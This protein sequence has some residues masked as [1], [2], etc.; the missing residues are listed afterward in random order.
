MHVDER[1]EESSEYY[2]M[3]LKT[4]KT[5]RLATEQLPSQAGRGREE[6][7]AG[8]GA[9]RAGNQGEDIG[10]WRKRK[11]GEEARG[12][13]EGGGSSSGGGRM[14]KRKKN[15]GA[16]GGRGRGNA[17]K[18]MPTSLS[19]TVGAQ[20]GGAQEKGVREV[21]EKKKE[22]ETGKEKKLGEDEEEE[23]VRLP[24]SP[25]RCAK[26]KENHKGV[27][28]C[29]QMGHVRAA[30]QVSKRT[31][32]RTVMFK[33]PNAAE[34]LE[35]SAPCIYTIKS[36][37]SADI[38][39]ISED[40]HTQSDVQVSRRVWIAVCLGCKVLRSLAQKSHGCMLPA[41]YHWWHRRWGGGGERKRHLCLREDCRPT[42]C[43]RWR[44]PVES[45]VGGIWQ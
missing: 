4:I 3:S 42:A 28:Y 17:V 36:R 41:V 39:R 45:Q 29:I 1:H 21:L 19:G 15:D 12:I 27:L 25:F 2:R 35:K 13:M 8:P 31:D 23:E 18:R 6:A 10:R 40:Q 20:E 5:L 24:E 14:A 9:V 11:Q 7:A 34:I 22:K 33:C 32:T 38:S 30:V 44:H 37:Y 43:E 16:D 26:C